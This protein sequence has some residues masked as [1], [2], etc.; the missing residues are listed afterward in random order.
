MFRFHRLCALLFLIVFVFSLGMA[1]SS[2]AME[3]D[4]HCCNIAATPDCSAGKGEWYSGK[5]HCNTFFD[6]RCAHIC[7]QCW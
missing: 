2:Q 3:D 1:V 7:P 6:L 4:K 5:C